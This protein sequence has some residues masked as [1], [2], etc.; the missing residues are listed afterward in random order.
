MKQYTAALIALQNDTYSLRKE[1]DE[2]DH[3][4]LRHYY[5]TTP[6]Q[7][8]SAVVQ[9][10][11]ETL[12]AFVRMQP[13]AQTALRTYWN[14][15]NQ[16]ICGSLL[17]HLTSKRYNP[18]HSAFALAPVGERVAALCAPALAP[19]PWGLRR[20]ASYRA[21]ERRDEPAAACRSAAL[22]ATAATSPHHGVP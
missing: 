15:C 12:Q 4:S 7:F 22:L 5:Q 21:E 10:Y 20:H 1:Q 19:S 18:G 3:L 16:W 9:T 2:P 14:V 11:D 17:W 8:L 6:E 13:P